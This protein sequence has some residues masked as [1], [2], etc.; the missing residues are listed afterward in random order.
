M[1]DDITAMR[2][3]LA[4]REQRIEALAELRRHRPAPVIA[5]VD[6]PFCRPRKWSRN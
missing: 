6:G 4:A 5:R 3:E 1:I 2:V